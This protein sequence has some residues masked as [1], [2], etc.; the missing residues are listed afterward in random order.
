MSFQYRLLETRLVP[1]GLIRQGIRARL[2]KKLE[3]EARGGPEAE[4]RRF[5]EFVAAT[6]RSPISVHADAANRQ[7]YEVP[8]EFFARVMGRRMKYSSG[9]WNEGVTDIDRSEEDMLA[10][11]VA[12]A[13]LADGQ[14]VLELGCGWGSLSLYMAEKFP[15]SRITAVSNSRSQKEFIDRRAAERGLKNLTVLTAEMSQLELPAVYER[16]VTVE[17]FEHMRNYE[18][19]FEKVAGFLVPNGTMFIHVFTHARYAYFYDET[20]PE[21]WIAQYFFTGGT[22]PSD[23]LFLEFQK[24]F[25]IEDHWRV[26]GL[27]Y[28]K[29]CHAWLRRMDASEREITPILRA[30]YGADADRWRMYWRLFFMACEELFGYNNGEEWMVSH[31]LFR[32]K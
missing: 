22:M 11:T 8:A 5:Q 23:G 25:A 28:Q 7:H 17:M 13:G 1:D 29:T 32:K 15:K 2:K 14:R 26:S 18:K 20:D 3:E 4:R 31:Y 24:D 6:R 9:L 12:R 16:V 30:V 21:D 27:H 19:L 10:L